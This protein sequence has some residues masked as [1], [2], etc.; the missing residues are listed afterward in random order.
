MQEMVIIRT[1]G[2]EYK[3]FVLHVE[4]RA[5]TSGA[6][7]VEVSKFVIAELLLCVEHSHQ[8]EF[9]E[10]ACFPTSVG[11]PLIIHF[12]SSTPILVLY[13]VRTLQVI[14]VCASTTVLT[15]FHHAESVM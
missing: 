4:L 11:Q 3:N 5:L 10:L 8:S 6:L 2:E 13:S 1:V 7:H 12:Y 9:T 14:H 15:S